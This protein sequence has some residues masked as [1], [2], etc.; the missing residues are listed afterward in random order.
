MVVAGVSGCRRKA[1]SDAV[2]APTESSQTLIDRSKGLYAQREDLNKLRLAINTLKE[3]RTHD[4]SNY[5][6]LWRL[7]QYN[8]YLGAHTTNDDER[9]R[10]FRD[11]IDAG[12]A[13][14]A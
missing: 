12:K 13:A 11:G 8:Y 14:V 1:K 9:G 7:S 6:I 4:Y 5:E 10:A 2:L 3:A